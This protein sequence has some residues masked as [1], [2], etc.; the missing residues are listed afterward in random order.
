MAKK[1]DIGSNEF[2]KLIANLPHQPNKNLIKRLDSKLFPLDM[3]R[4]YNYKPEH[5]ASQEF[6]RCLSLFIQRNP[7]LNPAQA[8]QRVA[9]VQKLIVQT[10][11]PYKARLEELAIRTIRDIYQVPEYL[12]LK[13]FIQPNIFLDTEQDHNPEPFLDLTLEQKN[14]MR[15]EI[16]KRVILNGL[17]HGSS[18]HIWKGVYHMVSTE[19]DQINP[20]LRELYDHYTSTLGI[21]IWDMNPDE[22]QIMIE[23]GQQLTQGFNKLTFD[24]KKGFGGQIQ[25]N[26]I[27]FPVLLHELNKGVID[28]LISGGIPK[29]YTQ[30]ELRYYYA[31][32]DDYMLEPY[33]Y[34]LS[35]SIWLGLLETIQV[36]NEEIPKILSKIL[37]LSYENLVQMFRLIQDD[38]EQAKIEVKKWI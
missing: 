15:D 22:F 12:D 25:A 36:D 32:S 31:K 7:G 1:K 3:N 11:Q 14:K 38:K 37:K 4:V 28:W 17:V 33:H 8:S 23:E 19:L 18:M 35:P 30:N 13:A 20:G 2:T 21:T 10:E 29:N 5:L 6:A 24:R 9:G 34:L 16:Q 26:G 27:N